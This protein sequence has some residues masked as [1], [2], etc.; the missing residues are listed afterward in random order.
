MAAQAASDKTAGGRK[1]SSIGSTIVELLIV[2]VIAAGA[3]FLLS[4]LNPP[5]AVKSPEEKTTSEAGS[6]EAGSK[7][8]GGK[9]GGGK[10]GAKNPACAMGPHIIDLPP[11]VTNLGAPVDTW[12]RVEASIVFDPKT[13]EHPE[14]VG[15]EIATDELAYLR[16]LALP[17]LQ[18]PIGLAN[19][20][21]DLA[22][23]AMIRSG[24]K[25]SEFIL[26]TLVVQ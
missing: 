8:G 24:G 5:A 25:V 21:Q 18:G 10:E 2:T 17:D 1:G 16:T 13:M 19:I 11:I 20:R 7:E 3:G 4:S 15:A 26:R 9:E 6:K 22:D 23:R 12:I 14:I